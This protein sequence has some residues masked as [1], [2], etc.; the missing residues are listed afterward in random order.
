MRRIED[1]ISFLLGKA[2]QQ[3][4]RRARAA[5]AGCD[6]TPVQYAVLAVLWEQDGQTGAEIG[7]RLVIDSATITGIID[8]LEAA[9]WIERRSDPA[10]DRRLNRL[11]LTPAGRALQGP[12]DAAMDRLNAE[13]RAEL[14]R[15]AP[16]LLGGLKQLGNV[17]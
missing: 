15:A 11:C 16:A 2:A 4:S 13:V 7:A 1:C 6:V 5:L 14:G 17:G 12:L 9:G 3:V 8:R 10:G